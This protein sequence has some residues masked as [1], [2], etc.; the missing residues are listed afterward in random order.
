MKATIRLD[1]DHHVGAIDRR[2]FSGFLEHLGRAV[3]EGVYDPDS[4]LTDGNGFRTDVLDA[5]KKL[6]MRTSGIRAATSS[7]T[8]TGAMASGLA[9]AVHRAPISPGRAL[10]QT[11]SALTNS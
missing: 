4:H 5:L 10:S 2:L 3:Y 6:R 1:T 9:T 8:T 7:A 11:R